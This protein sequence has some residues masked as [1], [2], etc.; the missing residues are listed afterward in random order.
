MAEAHGG[1]WPEDGAEGL[2]MKAGTG[3]SRT[4]RHS[5]SKILIVFRF[6][7]KKQEQK[8]EKNRNKIRKRIF[9]TIF[10]DLVYTQENF[11][12]IC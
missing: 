6:S 3:K 12:G 1:G 7:G 5:I 11:R 10:A 9:P 8:Q 2:G 4:D